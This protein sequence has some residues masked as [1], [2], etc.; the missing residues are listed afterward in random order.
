MEK[1]EKVTSIRLNPN[2]NLWFKTAKGDH[3]RSMQLI[4]DHLVNTAMRDGIPALGIPPADST[5][6]QTGRYMS[7]TNDVG[8]GV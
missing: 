2:Q 4:V 3:K 1:K 7:L 8:G 5:Y 6:T